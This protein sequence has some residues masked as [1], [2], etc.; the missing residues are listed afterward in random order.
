MTPQSASPSTQKL[1]AA[2]GM[3]SP[4]EDTMPMVPGAVEDHWATETQPARLPSTRALALKARKPSHSAAN[5]DTALHQAVFDDAPKRVSAL[6]G[7]GAG[8]DALNGGGDTP[9]LVAAQLDRYECCRLLLA[10]GADPSRRNAGGFPPLA[11]AASKNAARCLVMISIELHQRGGSL[12]AFCGGY[13]ALHW[14]CIQGSAACVAALLQAGADVNLESEPDGETALSKAVQYGAV[15]CVE[16]LLEESAV[17]VDAHDHCGRTALHQAARGGHADIVTLLL[18]RGAEVHV[19]DD[20]G[21]TPMGYASSRSFSVA[22]RLALHGAL[23]FDW[24]SPFAPVPAEASSFFACFDAEA[25]GCT[26]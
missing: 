25:P 19:R 16:A 1:D 20:E 8:V 13:T 7:A 6:L 2:L 14:A 23:K 21:V 15:D 26:P 9:L 3:L 4:L 12:D 5:G 11:L 24:R 22:H 10:A 18:N 17:I